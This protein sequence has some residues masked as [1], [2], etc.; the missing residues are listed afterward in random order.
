MAVMVCC[1]GGWV[2]EKG[3]RVARLMEE[4]KIV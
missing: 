1:H 2:E 4:G 3:K